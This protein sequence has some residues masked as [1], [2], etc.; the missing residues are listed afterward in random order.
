M[1][2]QLKYNQENVEPKQYLYYPNGDKK[3]VLVHILKE[4]DC[5]KCYEEKENHFTDGV[6]VYKRIWNTGV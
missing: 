3:A 4:G 1:P 2:K 5:P 6:K